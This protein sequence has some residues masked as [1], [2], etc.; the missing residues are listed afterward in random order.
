MGLR[1]HTVIAL[2]LLGAVATI[3]VAWGCEIFATVA[4]IDLSTTG[5]QRTRPPEVEGTWTTAGQFQIAVGFGRTSMWYT[6]LGSGDVGIHR[7]G[8]PFRAL[9]YQLDESAASRFMA[10]T[11][12]P[13]WALV[14]PPRLI[15]PRFLSDCPLPLRPLPV[16]FVLD[17]LIY[18]SIVI[19]LAAWLAARVRARARRRRGLCPSCGYPVGVSPVCT[20]CGAAIRG[21]A[22]AAPP[23]SAPE[24][25]A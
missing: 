22:V 25:R 7:A 8:W 2:M 18:A 4:V 1:A 24:Q 19:P 13:R 11:A 10:P 14:V 21:P 20:E 16:G 9:Q 12:R 3:L 17:T 5:P 15:V 6:G 23:V